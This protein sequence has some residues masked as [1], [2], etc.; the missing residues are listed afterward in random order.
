[1]C[2]VS[3]NCRYLQKLFF[4]NRTAANITSFQNNDTCFESYQNSEFG[5]RVYTLFTIVLLICVGLFVI[6][7]VVCVQPNASVEEKNKKNKN[8]KKKSNNE[9]DD[10]D[11]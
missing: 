9:E 3:R 4:T 11:W 7:V 10:D 1:M 8:K 5:E 6:G 2:V